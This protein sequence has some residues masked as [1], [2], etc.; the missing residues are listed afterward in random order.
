MRS[1]ATMARCWDQYREALK[2]QGSPT[3]LALI[4]FD[5]HEAALLRLVADLHEPMLDRDRP[6]FR[7]WVID[8]VPGGMF[9]MYTKTHHSAVAIESTTRSTNN[10]D[11]R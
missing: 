11:T 6:L 4:A 1:S 2:G 5:N 8:G 10:A 3:V 7:C 9:A